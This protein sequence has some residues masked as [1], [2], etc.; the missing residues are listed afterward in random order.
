MP[1]RY[2]C[3]E[4]GATIMELLEVNK[5]DG[6]KVTCPKCGREVNIFNWKDVLVRPITREE[7]K[8]EEPCQR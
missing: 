6:A 4:C 1:F 2:I 5:K 7:L 8:R 3:G